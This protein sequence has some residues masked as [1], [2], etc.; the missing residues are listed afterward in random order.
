MIIRYKS[1]HVDN[2]T[3]GQEKLPVYLNSRRVIF[4]Y[5]ELLLI[6]LLRFIF[7]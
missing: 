2:N 4:V 3:N 5:L 1:Y 7:P 6:K